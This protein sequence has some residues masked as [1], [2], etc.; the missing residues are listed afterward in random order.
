MH[1][2]CFFLI[3]G[4]SLEGAEQASGQKRKGGS[5]PDISKKG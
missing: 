5:T 3:A 4:L 1:A 2:Y